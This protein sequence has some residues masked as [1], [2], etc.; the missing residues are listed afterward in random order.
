MNTTK[1]V[2]TTLATCLFVFSA[3]DKKPSEQLIADVV[4]TKAKYAV[5]V[6]DIHSPFWSAVMEGVNDAK[7]ELNLDLVAQGTPAA[8]QSEE[9]LNLC[10]AMEL[11]KPDV[12]I[13][14]AVNHTNLLPCLRQASTRGALIIDLDG[15]LDF[16]ISKEADVNLA[17][18]VASD[19]YEIG[20]MAA[21]FLSDIS[22]KVLVI[23]GVPGSIPSEKRVAGFID[24][25]Q[26]LD[27]IASLNAN[28]DRQ[29]AADI[30][31][32]A[33]VA[34][35]D[36]KV[37][38]AANDGMA[39]GALQSV[40][41]QQ[42]DDILIVGVD[43]TADAVNAVKAGE[44]AAS[45]AQLPYLMGKT[46]V[47]TAHRKL[48]GMELPQITHVPIITLDKETLTQKNNELLQYLR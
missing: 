3:C 45:I 19:N 48:S 38:Y 24:H 46:S 22:G 18:R 7:N 47:E 9:Q 10:E 44:L 30:A 31:N 23:E 29:K 41:A 20:R 34:N 26:S 16:D 37:I 12:F 25:N 32:D 6:N 2:I 11:T 35:P 40:K 15:N 42:R 28:W 27:V 17:L 1:L 39:L 8:D 14:A 33:L 21:N 43:G 5:L 13:V 36:L 4:E